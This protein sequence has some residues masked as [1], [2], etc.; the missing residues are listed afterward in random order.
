MLGCYLIELVDIFDLLAYGFPGL[1]EGAG[2]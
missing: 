1:R 2:N